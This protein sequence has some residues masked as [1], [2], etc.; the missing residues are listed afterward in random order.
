MG[1]IMRFH[2]LLALA[3]L[4]AKPS[5]SQTADS[6]YLLKDG[7]TKQVNALW[8]ENPKE[9]QF[10]DGRSKVV[11]ADLKGPGVITMIHFAL[12]Q[13]MKLNRDTTLKIFWGKPIRASK[14]RWW[15]SSATRTARWSEW[16]PRW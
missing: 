9:M 4:I 2:V 12:P 3:L 6:L 7:E 11:I 8:G 14:R 1:K 16:I 13:A 5:S 15:T 10:G